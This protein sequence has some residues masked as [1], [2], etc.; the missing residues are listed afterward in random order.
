[1]DRPD[2]VCGEGVS[3]EAWPLLARMGADGAV[4]ALRP[5]PLR[6]MKLTAPD[7]TAFVGEYAGPREPGL[8]VRRWCL[9]RALLKCARGLLLRSSGKLSVDRQE[10]SREDDPQ[11][12]RNHFERESMRAMARAVHESVRA[13]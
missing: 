5:R 7:G 2:K 13:P 12:R 6:G 1:M 8:A 10:R 11:G 9:D 3:P 4:R